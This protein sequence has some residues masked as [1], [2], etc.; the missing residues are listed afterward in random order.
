M[1]PIVN[2]A[3]G[4]S[5][6]RSR[7][8][9]GAAHR[10]DCDRSVQKALCRDVYVDLVL[11]EAGQVLLSNSERGRLPTAS[12][13]TGDRSGTISRAAEEW[14]AN[15]DSPMMFTSKDAWV[16]D[17]LRQAGHTLLNGEEQAGISTL[18]LSAPAVGD[19][20]G[21]FSSDTPRNQAIRKLAKEWASM[22]SV[23]RTMWRL[24][25]Y[26]GYNLPEGE[27][28]LREDERAALAKMTVE[29]VANL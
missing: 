25:G 16:N 2:S 26:V 17:A 12:D 3:G 4:G 5:D 22:G 11:R 7:M 28:E 1:R 6:D 23:S 24:P 8:I 14:E 18:A 27:P 15:K 29:D 10:W 13:L 20:N 21:P 19:A 9:R